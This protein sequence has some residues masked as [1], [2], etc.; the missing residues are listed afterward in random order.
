MW[1]DVLQG[2][3]L[4]WNG[5]DVLSAPGGRTRCIGKSPLAQKESGKLNF[6]A[7]I[8]RSPWV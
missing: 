8:K 6:I 1:T 2:S 5:Q 7:L 4:G 3:G